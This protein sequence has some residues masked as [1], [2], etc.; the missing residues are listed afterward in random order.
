MTRGLRL[1]MKR[2]ADAGNFT[3]AAEL[4]AEACLIQAECDDVQ[5]KLKQ[6]RRGIDPATMSGTASYSSSA[7]EYDDDDADDE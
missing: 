2:A 1:E 6:M 5:A 3:Q 4:Q 7:S